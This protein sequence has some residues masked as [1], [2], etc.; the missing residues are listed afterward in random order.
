MKRES[1]P[2]SCSR[3]ANTRYDK[4]VTASFPQNHQYTESSF[5]ADLSKLQQGMGEQETLSV[6]EQMTEIQEEGVSP[7]YLSYSR[8]SLFP[9]LPLPILITERTS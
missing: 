6:K 8:L 1:Q 9:T 4:E 2:R 5:S 3:S 7:D